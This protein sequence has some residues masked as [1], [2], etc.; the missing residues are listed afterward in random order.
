MTTPQTVTLLLVDI[1]DS[2]GLI[3]RIGHE[4]AEELTA[5]QLGRLRKVV[6]S[7]EGTVVNTTG[8]G[9]LVSFP[10]AVLA[11]DA[12]AAMHRSVA[13]LNET[14]RYGVALQVRIALAASDAM[15]DGE[16]RGAA[17][18]YTARTEKL[19]PA[20]ETYCTEAVRLL[21][22]GRGAHEFVPLGPKSFKGVDEPVVLHR[23]RLPVADT[24]G[25]PETLDATQ[26][27]S[28]VGRAVEW[29]AV[30]GA[31]RRACSGSGEL[32]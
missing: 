22:L 9:L 17:A 24:L 10:A 15:L 28:F 23:V 31:W 19:V 18:I 25:M 5:E 32:L 26:R 11:L 3:A 6:E 14:R 2:T 16:F 4:R 27:Y 21:A 30:E 7:H 29:S 13:F 20:N 1:V 12:A 8:D